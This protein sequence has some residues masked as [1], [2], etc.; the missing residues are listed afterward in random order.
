M[1]QVVR[2]GWYRLRTGVARQWPGYLSIVL[3][4]GLIGGVAMASLAGAR[5]TESSFNVLLKSTN[6][7]DLAVLTGLFHPDPTGYDATLVKEI[8]HLPYVTRV[9]SEAGYESEMVTANG[10]PAPSALSG[11]QGVALYSSVD[12]V[13]F[14][15]D[16]LILLKG[17]LPNPQSPTQVAMTA[18]AAQAL[19]LRLGGT[20]DLGVVG[21]VQ[22]LS[23][24]QTCKPLRHSVL[25][26]VGIVTT[27]DQIVVDDSDVKETIFATPAY[28]KSLLRCCSD[29]TISFVQIA[30]GTRNLSKV[31][32]EI[33]RILPRG[34]PRR[35]GASASTVEATAQGVIGPEA[36]ALGIFGLIVALV[37]LIIAGQL[38]GRQLRSTSN[39]LD[40]MRALG[41]SPAM[42][43]AD[44]LLGVVGAVILGSLL[45]GLVAFL[46]SPLTPIGPVRPVY[47]SP[48]FAFDGLVLGCGVAVLIVALSGLAILIGYRRAPHRVARRALRRD[49]GGS[50][51]VRAAMAAG[52]PVTAV[53]GIR[54][55][56][57]PGQG[58]QASPVRS[59]VLGAV[60]AVSVLVAT[61]T[62]GSS[63]NTLT[64]R[65]SLYGWNWTEAMAAA[66]GV[67]V[68]PER[69]MNQQLNGDRNVAA[70]SGYDFAQLAFD[71]TS[72]PVLGVRPGAPVMPPQLSGHG[73]QGPGQVVF[74]AHTLSQL[75][76]RVGDTVIV[77]SN[78]RSRKLLIVGTA[79]LP[80]IGGQ[81][82][83]DPGT[84][85]VVDFQII[86]KAARNIFHL[87]GGGPN[88]VFVRLKDPANAAAL[89][90]LRK[91]AL[92][93]QRAAQDQVVVRPVQRPAE[94]VDAGTLRATPA[95]LAFAL[96]A[97]AVVALG[98]TLI[99]SVRRRRRDLALLKALG[100]TQ[101][102]LAAA[103][104]WQATVAAAIGLIVGVPLGILLGRVLWHLFARS[105][106]VVPEPTVPLTSLVF[107]IVGALI[108]A[109]VVALWPGRS[110][111]RTPA[112]LVLGAE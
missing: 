19:G 86:P 49:A 46:L 78:G 56:L 91:I 67:G 2:V 63:L 44:G 9:E 99:A 110:A 34:L 33:T 7:S 90:Q 24:C 23:N 61:L 59:A 32:S 16:Q 20:I 75:H 69:Q 14:N 35:L 101:R 74:G 50:G 51:I 71:G 17:R 22:G 53:C 21:D 41:A 62:F 5:R 72:E 112:A 55:A 107:L 4:I 60:V 89:A 18:K 13:F 73:L 92:V 8:A 43:S 47:P 80:A 57:V 70:W 76:K 39:E 79:T 36:I 30:G 37:A 84:G 27:S 109:N 95:Y 58:R 87:P 11:G 1:S 6:P 93:L 45:A 3:L 26:L 12:G 98:L 64:S 111:A 28:T 88:M 77:S 100:F 42:T 82:H 102:Q 104:A 83:T 38:L 15:M 85:A 97:G 108:F 105:I 68:L 103:V 52:L 81:P 31:E 25:T 96:A 94:V 29:P 66:G 54:F 48:G 65:P 40:S 10:D 106:N